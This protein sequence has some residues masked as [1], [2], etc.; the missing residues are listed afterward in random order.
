MS[1]DERQAA[2]DEKL[3]GIVDDDGQ[4]G[5]RTTYYATEEEYYEAIGD[6]YELGGVD[7]DRE[8]GQLWCTT[9]FALLLPTA[10]AV[11]KH[12]DMHPIRVD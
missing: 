6:P 10:E 1:D 3:Y 8:K 2:I 7:G 11:S 9:C 5:T 4:G 12:S